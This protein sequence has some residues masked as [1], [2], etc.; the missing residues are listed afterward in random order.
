MMRLHVRF[1]SWLDARCLAFLSLAAVCGWSVAARGDES[2]TAG[3]MELAAALK[4]YEDATALQASDPQ[5]ARRLFESCAQRLES[6]V[7]AGARNGWIE[8][9]LGNACFQKGSLGEAILHYRR[10]Q[11]TIPRDDDLRQNLAAARRRCL[12]AIAPPRSGALLRRAFFWHDTTSFGGR[13]TAALI[14]NAALWTFAAVFTLKRRRGW[15]YAAVV[16]AAMAIGA[17][18]SAA[19]QGWQEA[20]QPPGV[21]LAGDVAVFKGPG[22][23]YER[24]FEQPLQ[25][26]VEFT[27]T[28]RRGDWWRI[29][30]ADGQTGWIPARSAAL[31][32][33]S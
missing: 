1:G 29:E 13:V 11:R 16:A 17:G 19:V 10:A 3:G 6:L 7:T 26:G 12:T 18:G 15:L 27:R 2:V 14:A 8:Y 25:P 28:Q 32:V 33:G 31:V 4:E 20:R 22:T 23:G 21:V 30:L 5:A 9:N 24:Q